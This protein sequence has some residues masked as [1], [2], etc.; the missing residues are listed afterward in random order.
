MNV[1]RCRFWLCSSCNGV[2]EK[3]DLKQ[4]IIDYSGPGEVIVRGTV[5]CGNCHR[6]Y[7]QQNVYSGKHD[8]PRQHW[9]RI[10]AKDGRP[11][12]IDAAKTEGA[13]KT[14]PAGL[15][16]HAVGVPSTAPKVRETEEGHCSVCGKAIAA[17]NPFILAVSQPAG[18]STFKNL[19][20][21]WEDKQAVS[22]RVED[23]SRPVCDNCMMGVL[24]RWIKNAGNAG[25]MIATNQI[26]RKA[27]PGELCPQCLE[28]ASELI[29]GVLNDN[30]NLFDWFWWCTS[31]K[32][33]WW[34]SPENLPNSRPPYRTAE[35][36]QRDDEN[37]RKERQRREDERRKEEARKAEARQKEEARKAE[38]TRVQ[39]VKA[40]RQSAGQCENCGSTL[41][42]MD[43]LFK[44]RTHPACGTYKD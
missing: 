18:F 20:D 24:P 6:V 19:K 42:F 5:E 32:G 17:G 2:I 13:I 16:N 1:S 8:L 29:W 25:L 35:Q 7:Q 21:V 31:C 39:G 12:E 28:P 40:K 3:Q 43:R 36:R 41:R 11:I 23:S 27:S 37:E 4:R 9:A 33:K 34:Y 10:Q 14:G 15:P 22:K 26:A 38:E 30:S 44:R